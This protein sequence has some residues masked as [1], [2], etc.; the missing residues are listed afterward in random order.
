MTLIGK[1]A[2]TECPELDRA[3]SRSTPIGGDRKACDVTRDR[4]LVLSAS[5]ANSPLTGAG[6]VAGSL[7][8]GNVGRHVLLLLCLGLEVDT[9]VDPHIG[10]VNINEGIGGI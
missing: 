9:R 2:D 3:G 5:L 7:R 6:N 8:A 1:R 10:G 4:S